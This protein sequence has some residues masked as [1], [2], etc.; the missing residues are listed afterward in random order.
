MLLSRWKPDGRLLSWV[1]VRYNAASDRGRES[2]PRGSRD[3][4]QARH[5]QHG[6]QILP[7]RLDAHISYCAHIC[8]TLPHPAISELAPAQG[9]SPLVRN[10][11][12][13]RREH[14]TGTLYAALTCSTRVMLAQNWASLPAFP[15]ESS[16][17]PKVPLSRIL[18]ITKRAAQI[19]VTQHVLARKYESS[20][21]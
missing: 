14:L 20:G 17:W 16:R 11:A 19:L 6:S 12:H 4:H 15:A 2:P 10:D 9:Q 3:L 18:A 7:R 13:A 5:P 21:R 1:D 8:W